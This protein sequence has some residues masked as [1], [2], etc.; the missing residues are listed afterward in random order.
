MKTNILQKNYALL[1]SRERF[2][3]IYAASGRGDDAER[4]RLSRSAPRIT[5]SMPDHSPESHAFDELATL[6]FLELIED[7]R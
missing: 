1:K 7:E 6:I 4:E 5:L 3:L 2:C